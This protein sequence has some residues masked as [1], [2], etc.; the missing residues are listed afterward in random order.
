MARTDE[1]SRGRVTGI[2]GVFFKTAS[3]AETLGW[4]REHLGIQS[5]EYG[6][7]AFQWT[8]KTQPEQTGYTVWAAFPGD[9][10]YFDP[11][12]QPFM[13][14]FR[15]DDLEGLI[16]RL[17][18]AGVE[19]IGEVETHPNGKFGWILDPDG[20]KVELWEPVPSSQDPYLG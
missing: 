18:E 5:H 13:V 16:A 17:R 11:S 15:V 2:G 12:G 19:V 3:P 4:Y 8:E 9:T 6:G 14:N 7:F 1:P 20:R 10:E